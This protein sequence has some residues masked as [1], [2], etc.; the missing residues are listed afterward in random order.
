MTHLDSCVRS[1]VCKIHDINQFVLLAVIPCLRRNCDGNSVR[2]GTV[3]VKV[4]VVLFHARS[5]RFYSARSWRE[6]CEMWSVS[7]VQGLAGTAGAV[8]GQ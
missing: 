2:S 3:G 1:M 6:V 4:C 5:L 8:Y 7:A